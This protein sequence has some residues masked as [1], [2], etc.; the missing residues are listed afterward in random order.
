MRRGVAY[1]WRSAPGSAHVCTRTPLPGKLCATRGGGWLP[2]QGSRPAPFLAPCAAAACCGGVLRRRHAAAPPT[3]RPCSKAHA[4]PHTHGTAAPT[5]T[6]APAPTAA[7]T[8]TAAP[9]PT[10]AGQLPSP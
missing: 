5:P 10:G 1:R 4:P 9:T 2:P 8:R 3:G 6:A 7:P